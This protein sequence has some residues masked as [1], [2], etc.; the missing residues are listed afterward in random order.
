[1]I[2]V[3]MLWLVIAVSVSAADVVVTYR[4]EPAGA[5]VARAGQVFGLA[6]VKVRYPLPK[7]WTSC[8]TIPEIQVTWVSGA[9]QT[10]PAQPMCPPSHRGYDVVIRRPA[11]IRWLHLDEGLASF[12]QNPI[13]APTAWSYFDQERQLLEL[14]A[15]GP[16]PPPQGVSLPIQCFSTLLGNTLTTTCY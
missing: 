3:A 4:T 15:A 14:P 1:M 2:M 11:G 7:P 6:P 16:V 10:V 5:Q 13:L 9:S 8:V 12:L